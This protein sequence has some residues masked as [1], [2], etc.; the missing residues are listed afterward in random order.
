MTPLH[1]KRPLLKFC[2]NFG[3]LLLFFGGMTIGAVIAFVKDLQNA[4]SFTPVF[5]T[6]MM[7][8]VSVTLTVYLLFQYIKNS[9]A[10]SIHET[11]IT[12]NKETFLWRDLEKLSLTG[13]QPYRFIKTFPMEGMMFRFKDGTVKYA[14][15]DNYSNAPE[16]KAFIQAILTPRKEN[17]EDYQP[18]YLKSQ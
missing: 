9:P 15:D 8:A 13:K 3:L 6:C 14:Y 18:G 4:H 17:H 7:V 10:I 16:M 11:G 5:T 1:S 2:L 12:F